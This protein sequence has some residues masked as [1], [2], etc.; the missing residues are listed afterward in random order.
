MCEAPL[1]LMRRFSWVMLRPSIEPLSAAVS[2][3]RTVCL[4]PSETGPQTRLLAW[5]MHARLAIAALQPS[6]LCVLTVALWLAPFIQR[7]LWPACLFT[8]GQ[9]SAS[10]CTP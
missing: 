2:S 6:T 10:P 3:A 9:P 1:D 5:G 8:V 4:V 7:L